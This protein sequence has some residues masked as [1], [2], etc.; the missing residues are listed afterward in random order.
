MTRYK[1]DI[2]EK[3]RCADCVG[4]IKGYLWWDEERRK[5]VYGFQGAKDVGA[6]GMYN[7]SKTKGPIASIPEVPG[8]LVWKSG[9]IGVY[10]GNGELIEAKG[11]DYG[12]VKSKL[13]DRNFTNW[14]YCPWVTYDASTSNDGATPPSP[15]PVP[16]QPANAQATVKKGSK[17]NAVRDAQERL[18]IHGADL[19]VDG[20]FGPITDAATRAF[21][22][23]KT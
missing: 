3:R 14:C 6:T 1:K 15:I 10:I 20:I 11:F 8:V 7:A 19:K 22:R 23:D 18:V 17:G 21:Q 9:H 4:L 2:A 5:S 13:K 16:N 12:I